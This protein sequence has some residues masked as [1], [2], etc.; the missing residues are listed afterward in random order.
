MNCK[1]LKIAQAKSSQCDRLW[2][3]YYACKVNPYCPTEKLDKLLRLY[4]NC[5]SKN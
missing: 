3:R 1:F 4:E 5:I 2:E